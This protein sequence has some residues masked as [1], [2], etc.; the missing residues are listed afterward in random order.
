MNAEQLVAMGG[1]LWDKAGYARAYFDADTVKGVAFKVS[2]DM[3]G[4]KVRS[5]TLIGLPISNSRA[6]W[7]ETNFKDRKFKLYYDLNSKQWQYTYPCCGV[8]SERD[9]LLCINAFI[10]KIEKDGVLCI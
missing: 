2:Y 3:T 7:I 4:E 9:L 8:Q 6:S 10:A 1:T 5:A